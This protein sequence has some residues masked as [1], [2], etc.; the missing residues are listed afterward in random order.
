MKRKNKK[1][2]FL[3]SLLGCSTLIASILILSSCSGEINAQNFNKIKP[4]IT[5]PTTSTPE[6]D[7]NNGINLNP[8]TTKNELI[9]NKDTSNE[10]SMTSSQDDSDKLSTTQNDN[11]NNSTSS[12]NGNENI[13]EEIKSCGKPLKISRYWRSGNAFTIT[14]QSI[15]G[16]KFFNGSNNS[17][18]I[19]NLRIFAVNI[20][21]N[22]ILIDKNPQNQTIINSNPYYPGI[23]TTSQGKYH[24]EYDYENIE[25]NYVYNKNGVDSYPTGLGYFDGAHYGHHLYSNYGFRFNHSYTNNDNEVTFDINLPPVLNPAAKNCDGNSIKEPHQFEAN[26]TFYTSGYMF[27]LKCWNGELSPNNVS[28]IQSLE[29]QLEKALKEALKNYFSN[30]Y[31]KEDVK[32]RPPLSSFYIKYNNGDATNDPINHWQYDG[33]GYYGQWIA[34][35]IFRDFLKELY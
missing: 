11:K 23:I 5:N 19:P 12:T 13:L 33:N 24:A 14:L 22:L 9:E 25:L 4:I 18:W 21:Y 16:E 35:S 34:D 26:T 7:I 3:S 27:M 10:S 28:G 1:A 32:N 6:N 2:I 15:N 8:T 30:L 31:E 17:Y 20:P 29:D